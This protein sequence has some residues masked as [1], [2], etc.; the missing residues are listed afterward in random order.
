[1]PRLSIIIPALGDWEAL[2]T[3]LVAVLQNRPPRSEVLV[4][5]SEVYPDPYDL[6]EE[7]QFVQSTPGARTVELVNDGTAAAR[8]EVLHVLCCGATVGEGW[9]DPAVRH[10]SDPHVAA[11]A[12]LVLDSTCSTKVVSAGCT[13][14]SGGNWARF[15]S[16]QPEQAV[17]TAPKNWIGPELVAGFYRRSILTELGGFDKSL[18]AELAAIDVGLR[19][20][21]RGYRS[22]LETSS[23]LAI[24]TQ[25]LPRS[26]AFVQVWHSERLFWRHLPPRRRFRHLAAHG[27]MLI[28]E[29]L[30]HLARPGGMARTLGRLLGACDV[31]HARRREC[32]QTAFSS[33]SAPTADRRFDAPHG[34]RARQRGTA[35]CRKTASF[36]VREE[37]T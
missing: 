1:V 35:P 37:T 17:T 29:T 3:T 20:L 2:E 18:P 26:A 9:T 16:G 21:P 23:R 28:A 36:S 7:V 12:P 31:R 25:S 22:L 4:V 6:G 34:V 13:W 5:L 19:L 30:R 11:I 15:G 24:K 14:S 10:F 33:S 32:S 27:G 8:G